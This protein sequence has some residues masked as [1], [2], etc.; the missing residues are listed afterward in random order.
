MSDRTGLSQ[1]F[2]DQK[3]DRAV[4]LAKPPSPTPC[5][6]PGLRRQQLHGIY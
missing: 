6:I 1:L 2:L 3:C 4:H 5:K